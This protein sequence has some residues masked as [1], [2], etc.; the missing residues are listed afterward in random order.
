MLTRQQK[1]NENLD[2]FLSI[3]SDNGYPCNRPSVTFNNRTRAAGVCGTYG[4]QLSQHYLDAH[5]EEMVWNT[6]GHEF[7]HWIQR[8]HNLFTRSRTGKRDV[9]GPKFRSLCRML[10]VSDSR[11]HSMSLS[12]STVVRRKRPHTV[13]CGCSTHQ[14]TPRMYTRIL[15]GGY[16]CR[17]CK[18]TL[19][20]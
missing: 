19:T 7:A 9:H 5:E 13:K 11:T 18:G 10:G 15:A 8:T 2:L 6:L 4:I 14:V 17:K 3:A 12:E 16:N 20:V 1:I